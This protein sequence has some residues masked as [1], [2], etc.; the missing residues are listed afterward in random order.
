MF[1]EN[2]NE[3]AAALSKAQSQMSF[4]S[5]DSKNPHFGSKYADLSAVWASIRE[6]LTSNGL[7]VVQ[8]IEASDNKIFLVSMLM[9]VSGQWISSRM[10]VKTDKDTCQGMGSGITYARRYSLAALVGCVQ[11]DDDGNIAEGLS[12]NGA[13]GVKKGS[14]SKELSVEPTDDPFIDEAKK[15]LLKKLA[16][17]CD[18]DFANSI[19]S[20]LEKQKIN[21]FEGDIRQSVFERLSKGMKMNIENLACKSALHDAKGNAA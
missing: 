12:Q 19:Y 14:A 20:W 21:R 7:S 17:S 9:H 8:T 11:D 6:P 5:K 4:A 2:I 3:L 1:S 18:P 16:A 13:K 15:L 10:P